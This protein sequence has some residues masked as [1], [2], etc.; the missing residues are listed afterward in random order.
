MAY[1]RGESINLLLYR[2]VFSNIADHASCLQSGGIPKSEQ[3]VGDSGLEIKVMDRWYH[4]P[5]VE[6][7]LGRYEEPHLH[8][9]ITRGKVGGFSG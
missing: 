9:D 4:Y 7:P 3:E 2:V 8:V 1:Y 6:E 5:T